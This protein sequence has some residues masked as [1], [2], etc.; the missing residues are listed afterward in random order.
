VLAPN[1]KYTCRGSIWMKNRP[2]IGH[3]RSRIR[4]CLDAQ[5][6][7]AA[8]AK[9]TEQDNGASRSPQT[10]WSSCSRRSSRASPGHSGPIIDRS[11]IGVGFP[12]VGPYKPVFSEKV[13]SDR[14]DLAPTARRSRLFQN[15]K[16][17]Q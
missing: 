17:V 1:P 10:S 14:P 3:D 8:M 16:N 6:P 11:S 15:K 13:F 5:N 4:V 9:A 2:K 12:T 7:Y